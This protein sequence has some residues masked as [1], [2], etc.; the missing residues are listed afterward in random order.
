MSQ[1][2]DIFMRVNQV[3]PDLK[4]SER[5]HAR[6]AELARKSNDGSISADERRE[7]EEYVFVGDVLSILKAKAKAW[8]NKPAA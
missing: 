7:L 3:L 1:D 2:A 5:D 6:M 4:F 8:C